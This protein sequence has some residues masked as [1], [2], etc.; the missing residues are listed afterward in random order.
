MTREIGQSQQETAH[1]RRVLEILHVWYLSS[2]PFP[3]MWGPP[4]GKVGLQ[5]QFH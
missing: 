1:I 2:D 3:T 5:L 4:D